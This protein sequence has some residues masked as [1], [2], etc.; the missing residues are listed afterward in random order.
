MS[1]DFGRDVPDL[2]KNYARKLWADFSHPMLLPL[3]LLLAS[4]AV[5]D[6]YYPCCFCLLYLL[7]FWLWFVCLGIV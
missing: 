6:R 5:H 1:R 4:D 3:L 7:L 2:D